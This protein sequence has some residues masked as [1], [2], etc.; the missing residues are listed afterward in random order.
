MGSLQFLQKFIKLLIVNEI[1]LR[2]YSLNTYFQGAFRNNYQYL[3]LEY[4]IACFY[5]IIWWE[6]QGVLLDLH[7]GLHLE[8]AE[9]LSPCVSENEA[10]P[11][12][13][14]P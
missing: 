3:Q 14:L 11:W 12:K 8:T 7:Q 2:G 1:L 13:A 5:N 4:G 6:S 10:L 9:I